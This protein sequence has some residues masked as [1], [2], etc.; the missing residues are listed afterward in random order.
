V[1]LQAKKLN[2]VWLRVLG[3]GGLKEKE[4]LTAIALGFSASPNLSS[5]NK[6]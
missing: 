6:P 1:Q 5:V 2:Y 4:S 3:L